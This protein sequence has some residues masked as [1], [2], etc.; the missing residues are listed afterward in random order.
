MI[1]R[2]NGLFPALWTPTDASGTPLREEVGSQ[3]KFLQESGAD[4]VMALG[5]TGEFVQLDVQERIQ[6]L[7]AVANA[8]P[9]WPVIANCS[10][11]S[12]RRVTVLGAAARACGAAAI[13][14]LPPW[15]FASSEADIVEFMVRGAEAAELPLMLYNFPE[16]TGQRLSLETIAAVCDRVP[17][18]A[19]KQ[20][21]AEF[22]YHREL[23]GLAREKDFVLITGADT[24]IPEAFAL[25]ARGVVSGLANAIPELVLATLRA[26]EAGDAPAAA[27]AAGR[28]ATFAGELAGLQFPLDVAAAMEGRGRP[29]GVLKPWISTA[30]RARY[31]EVVAGTRACLAALGV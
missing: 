9:G 14:L 12:P 8:A 22:Q 3:V 28:V 29:V 27:V 26:V 10:D 19:L 4:G 7:Q 13:S 6:V 23:A 17:V 2:W 30:T 15:Y 11:T 5:S 25:G 21:G 24:R 18:V 20:S 1:P 31:A 16:R